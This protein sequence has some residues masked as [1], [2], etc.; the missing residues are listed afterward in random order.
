MCS[1][2]AVF[3]C[4]LVDNNFLCLFLSST[5]IL[6]SGSWVT[7]QFHLGLS[8]FQ[9]LIICTLDSSKPSVLISRKF[10][11]GYAVSFWIW[12]N[13]CNMI[14]SRSSNLPTNTI[15]LFF[16][17]S[18]IVHSGCVPQFYDP[19]VSWKMSPF[20][21]CVNSIGD[22]WV[23]ISGIRHWVTDYVWRNKVGS[24]VTN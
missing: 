8:I 12:I 9:T 17:H 5:V 4:F 7:Y 19:V 20:S 14:F 15:I 11:W 23:S 10:R 18:K 16:P 24:C 6:E 22:D 2:A 3:R 21:S 1:C 13:S